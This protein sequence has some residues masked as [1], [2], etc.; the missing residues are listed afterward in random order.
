MKSK[1]TCVHVCTVRLKKRDSCSEGTS[2]FIIKMRQ[3]N[4]S[5]YQLLLLWE[6]LAVVRMKLFLRKCSCKHLPSSACG[7]TSRSLSAHT[8]QPLHP[9][10]LI[11]STTYQLC[12][13]PICT[14]AACLADQMGQI[15]LTHTAGFFFPP[16]QQRYCFE[17]LSLLPW[18]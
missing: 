15:S 4:H 13:G 5:N 12:L 2:I 3:K 14:C 16:L 11:K 8:L 9:A 10:S 7:I 6:Q 1:N 18:P 17:S